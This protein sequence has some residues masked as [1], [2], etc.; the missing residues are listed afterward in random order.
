MTETKA[1]P[2]RNALPLGRWRCILGLGTGLLASAIGQIHHMDTILNT[3][4]VVLVGITGLILTLFAEYR[5]WRDSDEYIRCLDHRAMLI[6]G[7]LGCIISPCLF[8]VTW[9]DLPDYAGHISVIFSLTGW[10]LLRS[11]LPMMWERQDEKA[12]NS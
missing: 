11:F 1:D 9:I 12:A 2:I 5:I 6:A 7:L 3:P 10:G 4:S 8:L